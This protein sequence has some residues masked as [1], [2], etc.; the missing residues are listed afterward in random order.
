MDHFTELTAELTAELPAELTARQKQY[1]YYRDLLLTFDESVPRRNWNGQ[2]SRLDDLIAKL[3]PDGV[4]Y[5][6][7]DTV[8]H[9]ITAPRKLNR[10]TYQDFGKYPII[11]QGQNLIAGY[12]DDKDTLVEPGEYV[13]FGEHTREIKY[14]NF[15]FAQ[16]AD[17]IK[18]LKAGTNIIPKFLYHALTHLDISD[19]GY[20][21]HWVIVKD[22]TIP[23]PPL[24]IQEEIVR[25]LDHF[26]ELTA[27]LTAGLTNEIEARRKQ[28]E[29]YRDKLLTF[30]EIS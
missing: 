27:E 17:G 30:K 21:R 28:Y 23:L 29:Y 18:I 25:I 7:V 4:E 5:R 1:E 6:T 14:V 3:C 15:T 10:K 12:T 9:N 24:P 8:C 16:G 20:N 22:M 13:I 26:T 19:R 2:V 11:D